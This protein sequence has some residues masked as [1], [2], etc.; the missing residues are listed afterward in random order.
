VELEET[1]M[2]ALRER[3][4]REMVLRRMALRTRHSYAEAV[5]ALAKHYRRSP[6]RL[7][8]EEIQSYLLYL[9]EERKLAR[10]SCL[11]A[12]H[13]LRF[14]Y[15]DTLKRK[16][17]QFGVPRTRV[18]QKLPQVLSREEIERLIAAPT[19][20]KHRVLLMTTYAAG[21]RV[22]EVC[23][24]KVTDLDSQR[25]TIRVEQ[26]KGQ[27]DRYSLLSPRLLSDLRRYWQIDRPAVWLFP[28][29]RSADRAM[30]PHTAQKVF[31]AARDKASITKRCGI[32][33][34]RHAFATH[35]LEAGVDV[36]T[37]QR[38]MGHGDIQTTMRYVHLAQQKIT[39]TRSPLEL[40]ARA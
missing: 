2:G 22:S 39:A 20:F 4:E 15:H 35:L 25:M 23:A 40:L 12:L 3:M 29:A 28:A 18:P 34:L 7:T 5:A 11:V 8:Q 19:Q 31:Y 37:I 9:I 32:H 30:H 17:L 16:E 38:L 26:G 33:A 36:H 6:E 27:K 10:S 13:A 21:L 14:F 24:L 1:E